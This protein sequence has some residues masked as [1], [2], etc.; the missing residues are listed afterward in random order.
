MELFN[1]LLKVSA[2][3]ALFF[4]FYLVVLRKLTFFKINRFYLLF[5]LIVSFIIPAL[6]FTIARE[7]TAEVQEVV[8]SPNAS[9]QEE[10]NQ[11]ILQ[12]NISVDSLQ[13]KH[14]GNLN[15]LEV[16]PFI[17]GAIVLGILFIMLMQL[18][19]LLKYTSAPVKKINGLKL[20]AKRTGFTNCSFFNYVF[21]DEHRLTPTEL[22]VLLAHEEV[23]A[24]QFHSVDKL[25]LMI[26][27]SVLWF[28]PIIYLYDKA[29]EQTHEYEAD[30][31]TSTQ[32]GAENY[33][34]LLIKL[35]ISKSTNPLLHN[36]V[37]SPIKQ[38]IKM[39]FTS[40]SKGMKKLNYVLAIPMAL[41]L[42]WLLA[43]EVV[44][45]T[46]NNEVLVQDKPFFERV[47]TKDQ[48]GY[49]YEKITVNSPGK[50][51]SHGIGFSKKNELT[52]KTFWF[53][54]NG[55]LYTEAEVNK[56]DAAFV[57]GLPTTK[58]FGT[59][60][61]FDLPGVGSGFSNFVFWIGKEPKLS[62]YTAK[63]RAIFQ[64]YNGT[65]ITGT[66]MEYSYSPASKT[67]M[68]G[69]IVKTDDGVL[70]KAFVEA[71]FVKQA[72]AMVKKGEQVTIKIYNSAYWKDNAYP[73]LSSFKLMKNDKVLFD[74]WPKTASTKSTKKVSTES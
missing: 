31:A 25:I 42:V 50:P 32:V 29:L 27:K 5:S 20:V 52:P 35:A 14:T 22:A 39:L 2:C 11:S 7:M 21:I 46:V 44:Y 16:L 68:D 71:K 59:G 40:K 3:T 30:Q 34:A 23:H 53:Y 69:F 47:K 15:W 19:Q 37:K 61:D 64:K 28:N 45:A 33:A 54:I 18:Y 38:R 58:G 26:A 56:F 63:N 41:C 73:V 8:I 10:A 48:S 57:K 67:L 1:Y 17:Y 12:S 70:L 72:N 62:D 4:A 9:K 13:V 49:V 6:Q 60:N 51:L 65:T 74:R 55:K 66:V 36:F 43:T 24:K